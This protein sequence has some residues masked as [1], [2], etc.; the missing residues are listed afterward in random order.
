MSFM[1][2]S[3]KIEPH[4]QVDKIGKIRVLEPKDMWPKIYNHTNMLFVLQILSKFSVEYVYL[5]S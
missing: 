1:A 5:I 3:M 2:C 4:C